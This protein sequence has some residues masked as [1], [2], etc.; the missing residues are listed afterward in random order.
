MQTPLV[1]LLL[2]LYV[3]VKRVYVRAP[4]TQT[5]KL[6]LFRVK[7]LALWCVL[8]NLNIIKKNNESHLF[9]HQHSQHFELLASSC[10]LLQ[11]SWLASSSQVSTARIT[12]A[13]HV[14]RWHC[15]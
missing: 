2:L 6:S 1:L 14:V 8:L 10:I 12:A 13:R 7:L 11:A 4:C 15:F 3:D 5:R 9:V